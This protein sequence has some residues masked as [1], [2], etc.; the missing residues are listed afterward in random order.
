L[1][2]APA[3][4]TAV[5]TEPRIRHLVSINDLSNDE[6]FSLFSEADRYLATLGDPVL[7]YRIA[8]GLSIANGKIAASL[9]YEPSTRTRLSFETAMIRLGGQVITSADPQASSTSKGE[10]LADTVRVVSNYADLIVLRHPR[11]GAARYASDFAHIPVINAGDGGHEH[12]TQ[13]LCDLFTLTEEHKEFRNLNIT[14]SGDLKGSRTIHSLVYALARLGS[15]MRLLPAKGMEL[16]ANV[17]RRLRNEFGGRTEADESAIGA[18]YITPDQPHQPALFTEPEL[19]ASS[20]VGDRVDAVYVTRYQ[21]ERHSDEGERDYP[22]VD[23]KFLKDPK[24]SKSSVLHPLPRVDELDT[25]L[26]TDRR[27]AYFRQAAY[28]VPVRMALIAMILGLDPAKRLR[29]FVGGFRDTGAIVIDQ[30]EGAGLK[31]PN[32][33]C[34]SHDRSEKPHLRDKFTYVTYT[35][36]VLRCF[37]CESDIDSFVIGDKRHRRIYTRQPKPATPRNLVC[38]T[39]E[40]QARQAGFSQA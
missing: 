20:P 9:F 11:D 22:R 35:P 3:K 29:N 2:Q 26:D 34:I 30:P 25:D 12:P 15:K 38:F 28:G 24:Y 6:I 16:P 32:R 19:P 14:I 33:N 27:A 8:S 37:Y 21:K 40:A 13:T 31:C 39:D 10:S 17:E 7:G 4:K 18:W 5:E 23:K 1:S 36:P